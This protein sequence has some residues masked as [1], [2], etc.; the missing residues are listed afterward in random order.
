MMNVAVSELFV[1]TVADGFR[2]RAWREPEV[3]TLQ[4]QLKA[5]S[6]LSFMTSAF[7]NETAGNATFMEDLLTTGENIPESVKRHKDSF[8]PKGWFYQNLVTLAQWNEEYLQ[9]ISSKEGRIYPEKIDEIENKVNAITG[10]HPRTFF[11]AKVT[12]NFSP[13]FQVVASA[14]TKVSQGRIA[15]ALERFHLAN[16]NYPETLDALVP[17]FIETIPHDIIGGLPLRYRRL[18]SGTFLLYS[19]GWDEVDDGGKMLK[20]QNGFEGRFQG[21]WVWKN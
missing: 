2:L 19:V 11:A 10:F 7:Q 3:V 15:C 5:I 17:Q 13:A 4:S 14:Q 16:G 6:L 20:D 21:D 9:G 8:I 12:P 1:N 18:E